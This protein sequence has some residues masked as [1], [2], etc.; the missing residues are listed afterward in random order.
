MPPR[1]PATSASPGEDLAGPDAS[2]VTGATLNVNGGFM[3]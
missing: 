1:Q 2:F 3:A